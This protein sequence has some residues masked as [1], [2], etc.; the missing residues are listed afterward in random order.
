M[1]HRLCTIR[2][3]QRFAKQS[4]TM[5]STKT[6]LTPKKSSAFALVTS[7]T[8]GGGVALSYTTTASPAQAAAPTYTLQQLQGLKDRIQSL[9]KMLKDQLLAQPPS[10]EFKNVQLIDS[11]GTFVPF[12]GQGSGS[13]IAHCPLSTVH[14]PPSF[15]SVHRQSD[16]APTT[17]F[18]SASDVPF[19][20]RCACSSLSFVT[21]ARPTQNMSAMPIV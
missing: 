19:S 21:K 4:R 2:N 10:A 3:A 18:F 8:I 7:L 13:C 14:C 6:S 12:H 20:Q 5:F 15:S 11:P 16:N 1:F 9:E 17:T